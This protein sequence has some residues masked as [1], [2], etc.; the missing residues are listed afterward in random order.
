MRLYD[1]PAQYPV[2]PFY[3]ANQ[4]DKKAA[5]DAGNP[6]SNNFSTINSTVQFRLYSSVLRNYPN[7]Y[8]YLATTTWNSTVTMRKAST[9]AGL[10][11]ATDQVVFNL[12][13]PNGAGTMWAPEFHLLDG[14]NGKRN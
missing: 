9:L 11:T 1:D 7:S 10:A 8:Y 12:T 6:G 5:A 13:R 4:V 2:F 3:T 14:P